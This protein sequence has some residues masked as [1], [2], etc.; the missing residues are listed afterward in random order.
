MHRLLQILKAAHERGD[1][2]AAL[3]DEADGHTRL[4]ELQQH[5]NQA[6]YEKAVGIIEKYLGVEDEE[7]ENIRPNFL[8]DG[9]AQ[10]A[11]TF[12]FGVPQGVS[13]NYNFQGFGSAA[14]PTS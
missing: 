7:D 10:Q 13:G 9:S 1:S 11:G 5:E 2:Y 3:L 12:A 14:H 4:E 6:I 8:P